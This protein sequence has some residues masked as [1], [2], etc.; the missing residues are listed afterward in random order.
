VC[1]IVAILLFLSQLLEIPA[2]SALRGYDNTFNYLWLRSAW[3]DGDWDFRNDLEQCNTLVAEQR[4]SALALPQTKAGRIPNKYGIGWALLSV[5]FYGVADA[6]VAIG[7]AAGVWS[8]PRD[9]YNPIYQLCL[10][11]GHAGLALLSLLLASRAVSTW[12]GDRK[13]AAAGVALVWAASP[14]LYYQ[15]VNL[16]MSH[17]AAFF[18]IALY[19]WSLERA[20]QAPARVAPWIIA[21]AAFGLAVITRFQLAIFGG[22]A[23]WVLFSCARPARRAAKSALLLVLGAVPFVV[24]QLYAWRR[25][26]G[27]WLV[28]SYGAE[29]E[30]F[31]WAKPEVLKTLFSSWHGLFYWHPFLLIATVAM[32]GWAW[33]RR[34]VAGPWSLSLILTMYVSG[35]WWCWWFAAAF[36]N[37]SFDAAL[38]P[39]MGGVAWAIARGTPRI[40]TMVWTLGIFAGVWN[41]YVVLLFRSG[42]ISR[43]LPV[44]WA[45]MIRAAARLREAVQF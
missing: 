15:T 10:Q 6:V 40:R 11:V 33:E 41:F 42:A 28:F 21:G 9:G 36:G 8:F 12:I 44:T 7:R 27:E 17:G 25:V 23:V 43:H 14:L 37:R 31:H 32:F 30:T 39:L 1:G 16:S 38:L 5:P 35:A 45:E 26:Y 18:C 19:A 24:L 4:A 2:R 22:A 34:S 29:G 3:V 20:R 13:A